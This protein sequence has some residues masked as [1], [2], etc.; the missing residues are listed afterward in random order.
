ML[1]L[2]KAFPVFVLTRALIAQ[3]SADFGDH[4]RSNA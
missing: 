2:L 4:H 3:Q 1:D